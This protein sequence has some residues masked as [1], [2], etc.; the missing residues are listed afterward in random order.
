MLLTV[1]ALFATHHFSTQAATLGE[2]SSWSDFLR[3][4]RAELGEQG[5]TA[6]SFLAQHRPAADA[7]LADEDL[8][9]DNLRLALETRAAYP[10]GPTI[11]DELFLNDVLPYAVLDESRE[12]WRPRLAEIAAPLVKDAASIEE[13]VQAINAGLF[14]ACLLYTSPSPR[15]QRGS[16]MPSSA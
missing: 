7:D 9:L 15:D 12:N 10:W 2:P 14:K 11:S 5:A 1:F 13:A 8:L 4:A 3:D 16:R 6:A